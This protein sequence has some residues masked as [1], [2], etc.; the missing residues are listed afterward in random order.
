MFCQINI[1]RKVC[2]FSAY[3]N[4]GKENSVSLSLLLE[5]TT[6]SPCDDGRVTVTNGKDDEETQNNDMKICICVGGCQNGSI[7]VVAIVRNR[8]VVIVALRLT[9]P[10]HLVLRL[11]ALNQRHLSI[12][13]FALV[14]NDPWDPPF[15][16][17]TH[18]IIV[19]QSPLPH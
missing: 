4:I 7:D 12:H 11:T 14:P 8:V 10:F 6:N 9:V 19:P 13:V 2:P 17:R 3:G 16:N 1:S 18:P 15:L 5:R